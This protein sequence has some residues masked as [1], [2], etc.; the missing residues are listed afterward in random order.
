[1]KNA[2]LKSALSLLA[3]ALLSSNIHAQETRPPGNTG[4][5]FFTKNGRIYD[6]GGTE[7][8]PIG[9]NAA[10]YWDPG[11]ATCKRNSMSNNL[12]A[13]GA[14]TVR[15]VTQTQG[16][17]GWNANP[18][19]QR[20]L[21]NRSVQGS[22][23][24]ML[25]MH[26]ATC[27]NDA[28]TTIVNYW[29]S[30]AMVQLCQDF[31]RYM[32]VNIANEHDFDTPE[33]W[34]DG[35]INAIQQLRAAGIRNLIVVDA[36]RN[37]GQNPT[38]ITQY[39][40]AVINADPQHNVLFSVHMY[41]FWRTNDKT[42]TGWVPPYR[43]EVDLPAIKN[44]GLPIIV[45][46]FGW[47][48]VNENYTAQTLINICD[49]HNIGWY[50]WSEYDQ[51]SKPHYSII[52]DICGNISAGNRTPAGNFIIPY[53]QS[54]AVRAPVFGGGNPGGNTVEG[55]SWASQS[56]GGNSSAQPGYTGSGYFDMGGNG[57]W[58]Q[59][60][61]NAP[62]AGTYN[63]SFRFAN[64]GGTNRSCFITV[65]GTNGSTQN[66][67]SNGSWSNW[68]TA[69]FT[70]ISL[71]A[72][73]NTIRL[74]ANSANGG[75]N[76]DNLSRAAGSS[77]PSTVT[78]QAENFTTQSGGGNSTA[79]TGYTGT[80]YYDMGGNGT[81]SEYVFNISSAGS[82]NLAIRYANGGTTNRP[83]NVITNGNSVNNNF[84]P[85]GGWTTWTETNSAINLNGGNNT[86][87]IQ[88]TSANGGANIDRL[89]ISPSSP[90][91]V[92]SSSITIRAQEK[93]LLL[94]PNPATNKVRIEGTTT[95]TVQISTITGQLI[96]T[97]ITNN[98]I[99]DITDLSKG[100]YIVK[101]K[102]KIF[103]LVKE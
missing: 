80:G 65:N 38:M 21:V 57:S 58:G 89:V 10:V 7:F 49:Q 63:I 37:C 90:G 54:N 77:P 95:G 85:T 53:M 42:F 59:W 64:G 26:D 76:I 81:W 66:F 87:R 79:Q 83:A 73:N 35:Y 82:Y 14:N 23:V 13:S 98:G 78:I 15:I 96:K 24:P 3:V 70:G 28:F 62:S 40:Q 27:D 16:A 30:A 61:V 67:P 68:Q 41:Q 22:M 93:S 56:G 32:W 88:A 97:V 84:A 25:E 4:T 1:M 12:P 44:A 9:L 36:G 100:V 17:F 60:N 52:V 92:M 102:E 50:F 75:P 101:V 99:I 47:N 55:E 43:V 29:R 74:T 103:K 72:G 51:A 45:G 8:I 31:E 46:E 2:L 48:S 18:T 69:T 20:D 19:D 5:G 94:Y 33:A 11:T 71:N 86:I 91:S 6:P 39:G 34:R